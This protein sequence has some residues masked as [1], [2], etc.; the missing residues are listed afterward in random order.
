MFKFFQTI[1][2]LKKLK[3][4]EPQKKWLK[5]QRLYFIKMMGGEETDSISKTSISVFFKSRLIISL[6][7]LIV[8]FSLG[9]GTIY[10][11]RAALPSDTL[12]PVKLFIEKVQE[13]LARGNEN[14]IDLALK[15]AEKR[16]EEL[17]SVKNDNLAAEAIARSQNNLEKVEELIKRS[18]D[19]QVNGDNNLKQMENALKKLEKIS[20]RKIRLAEKFK[21]ETPGL[22]KALNSLDLAS[23][24]IEEEA[25]KIIIAIPNETASTTNRI[26]II[27][28]QAK[29]AIER[30]K[31]KIGNIQIKDNFEDN[32]KDEKPEKNRNRSL[33][34]LEQL[35]DKLENSAKKLEDAAENLNDS[36]KEF[37]ERDFEKAVKKA[38]EAFRKAVS[39]ESDYDE[40]R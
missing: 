22:T 12:F 39:A 35:A 40:S 9:S 21:N 30:A 34:E 10:S 15:L 7:A 26:N 24:K 8:I 16:L 3:G 28:G 32:G 36:K 38:N 37:N 19:S 4:I 23:I 14:K 1:K 13:L 11:A 31:K 2:N 33:K 25:N 29:K 20:E 6:T 18:A 5:N 27:Q 17:E